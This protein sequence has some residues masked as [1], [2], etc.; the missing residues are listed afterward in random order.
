MLQAMRFSDIQ[1]TI[2]ALFLT[3]S[4]MGNFSL[5]ALAQHH[6]LTKEQEAEAEFTRVEEMTWPPKVLDTLTDEVQERLGFRIGISE[7]APGLRVLEIDD[8]AQ[9][10]GLRLG[11]RVLAARADETEMR[12]TYARY[13]VRYVA[14]MP[15]SASFYLNSKSQPKRSKDSEKLR[16][17]S[18]ASIDDESANSSSEDKTEKATYKN[19]PTHAQKSAF[20]ETESRTDGIAA[21]VATKHTVVPTPDAVVDNSS[22]FSRS[23]RLV[24]KQSKTVDG[25]QPQAEESHSQASDG[26]TANGKQPF[27]LNAHKMALASENEPIRAA[28]MMKARASVGALADYSVE[29]IIDASRS[30][31]T[32]DV[33][34]MVSRWEWCGKQAQEL[35]TLIEPFLPRGLNLTTFHSD[36][37]VYENASPQKIDELFKHT[38]LQYGTMLA[39]PLRDRLQK[40]FAT[41]GARSKPLL[42][43]VISDGMPLPPPEPTMVANLLVDASKKMRNPNEIT[44]VFFQIGGRDSKGR[45]YLS[46]LD[47][48][49]TKFGAR[50]DLVRIVPFEELTRI[51]LA[52]ALCDAISNKHAV[53]SAS[54]LP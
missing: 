49:L 40:Y 11:D 30:M 29:I 7:K 46:D 8:K 17:G 33:P 9:R 4:V 41:R 10:A 20:E 22:V 2:C 38:H 43:C 39:E 19:S 18:R 53:N 31:M 5:C 54:A 6:K 26:Q 3:A 16:S 32:H 15:L 25:V 45:K 36:Y 50:Y 51:G 21:S 13:G 47:T 23:D 44:L 24:M 42:I 37:K 52:Q 34:G 28:S 27:V 35:A 1:K 48:Q 12:I 14:R